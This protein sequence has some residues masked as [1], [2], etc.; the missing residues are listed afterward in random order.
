MTSDAKEKEDEEWEEDFR[1]GNED[2]EEDER[3]NDNQKKPSLVM[4]AFHFAAFG[5]NPF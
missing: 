4:K 1:V 5:D 3:T 2:K